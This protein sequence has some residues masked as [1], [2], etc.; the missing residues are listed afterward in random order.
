MRRSVDVGHGVSDRP[1]AHDVDAISSEERGEHI[2][3]IVVVVDH[4]AGHTGQ[5]KSSRGAQCPPA[6]NHQPSRC[7][8][9]RWAAIGVTRA[10]E[11]FSTVAARARSWPSPSAW[12]RRAKTAPFM[13]RVL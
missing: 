13:K 8:R 9:A 10:F 4:D 5:F 11:R 12:S 1:G 3:D 6:R 7:E 2:D